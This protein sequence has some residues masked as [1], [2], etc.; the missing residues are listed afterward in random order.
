MINIAIFASGN[1]SNAENI[2]AYFKDNPRVCVK[3]I[4]SNSSKAFVIERAA[5][6]KIPSIIISK[7]ELQNNSGIT[8]ILTDHQI[9][10]IVLA[11]FLLLIPLYLIEVFPDKIINLH[12]ALLPKFGGKGMYGMH[13]HNAVIVTEEMESG[14]TI[15]FV[16]PHYDEGKIIAQHKCTVSPDDTP[17]TLAHK[18]H[19]LEY[20]YYPQEIDKLII[21]NN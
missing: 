4:I 12:P 15:H 8:R 21:N 20:K 19:Q 10:W 6:N 2:I 3:L 14:I 9:N 16:N 5:N 13:V 11:G 17:E 7:Q 1:G 18:I